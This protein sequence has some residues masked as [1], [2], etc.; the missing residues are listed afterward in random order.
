MTYV[1]TESGAVVRYPYDL[2]NLRAENPHT[3]FPKVPSAESLAQVGVFA[4]TPTT[5]PDANSEQIVVEGEPVKVGQVWKQSWTIRNKTA[6]ELAD[7][8]AAR[9]TEVNALKVAKQSG[10]APTSQGAVDCDTDSRNKLNGA[11]LMAM[12]ALQNSQPFALSWTMADNTQVSL[13]AIGAI[14]LGQEVGGYIAAVHGHAITLKTAIDAATSF[15]EL[16]AI[17]IDAGW[18]S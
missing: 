11:V 2:S 14:A 1:K 7:A 12:L 5:K 8:K 13:D 6:Q 3:M 10:Q 9:R 4:V 17:D 18:P 16:A 15:A